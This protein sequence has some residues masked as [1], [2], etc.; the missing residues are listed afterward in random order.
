[1]VI[2][3]IIQIGN[4]VIRKKSKKIEIKD[5]KSVKVK[6]IIK[7]LV[8]SMR[9]YNL[10]GISAPQINENLRIFVTEIRQT[11]NRKT[12]ELDQIRVFINP[13]ITYFSKEKS[14]GYEGCGSVANS[15]LF[16]LV[17]RPKSITIRAQDIEGEWFEFNAKGLLARVIQHE[18]DHLDGVLFIDKVTNTK[19]YMSGSEY[20]KKNKK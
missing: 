12:K 7:N 4:P 15:N 3:E 6:T 9:H 20:I 14:N 2:K 8:D 18:Y 11:K 17:N 13:K 5:I 1:M 10:I 19:S 16:G